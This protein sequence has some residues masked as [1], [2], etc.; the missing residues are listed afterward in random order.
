MPLAFILLN[1]PIHVHYKAHV[2][3]VNLMTDQANFPEDWNECFMNI[4]PYNASRPIQ[5]N[6][7]H[8][9]FPQMHMVERGSKLVY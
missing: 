6:K 2:N 4:A 8:S 9:S 1:Q 7:D 3:G 5:R